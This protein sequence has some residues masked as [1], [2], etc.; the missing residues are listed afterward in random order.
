MVTDLLPKLSFMPENTFTQLLSR[1]GSRLYEIR[2][3]KNEKI[4]NVARSINKSSSMV[5]MVENGRYTPLSLQLIKKF[6]EHYDVE[7]DDLLAPPDK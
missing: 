2:R 4:A 5:S 6:A 3:T 1:I 7:I